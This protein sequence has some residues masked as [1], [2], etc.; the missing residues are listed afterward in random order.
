VAY[1]SPR[2]VINA[3]AAAAAAHAG[4]SNNQKALLGAM[5]II[6]AANLGSSSDSDSDSSGVWI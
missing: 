3:A 2:S 6:K 4:L 1:V 5:K